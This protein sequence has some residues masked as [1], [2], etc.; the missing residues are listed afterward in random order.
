MTLKKALLIPLLGSVV[1]FALFSPQIAVSA[2]V[3]GH[4][5]SLTHGFALA[6]AV[7]IALQF[8]G[9]LVRS[10]KMQYVLKPIR[11][12]TTKFQFRALS[13]GYLFNTL[14]PLRLGELIRSYIMAAGEKMS[15]GLSL[16]LVLFERS[17]DAIILAIVIILLSVVGWIGGREAL[18]I[19]CLLMAFALLV[20]AMFWLSIKEN[21]LLIGAVNRISQLFNRRISREIRFKIWSVIYGLQKTLVAKRLLKYIAL[22]V[23]SWGLYILSMVVLVIQFTGVTSSYKN[24]VLASVG[25][26]IGVSIPAGPA[27]L[28]MYSSATNVI[29]KQ[30]VWTDEQRLVADLVSWAVLVLPICTVAVILLLIKTNEPL[31]RKLSAFSTKSSLMDK[32]ARHEDI[33]GDM[34]VFLDSYFAGNPLSKIVHNLE[35]EGSLH[36]LKYF[37]GGSDAITILVADDKQGVIVKK[38]ISI[39]YKDRL[40]AQYDWLRR[41]QGIGIVRALDETTAKDHYAIDLEYDEQNEMFFDFIHHSSMQENARVMKEVWQT[42]HDNLYKNTSTVTDYIALDAYIKKHI[43]GCLDMAAETHAGISRVIQCKNVQINGNKYDN[44]REIIKKIMANKQARKDLATFA[45]AAEV[46]GD[47]ALDNILVSRSTG[48]PLI[49]DPAP[50][51]NIINGPVFDFGK[52]MQSLYCGYE[53]LFRS[54]EKVVLENDNEI[55]FQDRR[56]GQY[57][58]LCE[59]VR[60]TLASEYLSEGEQKAMIFHAAALHIRRLKHQVKQNPDIALAMYAV[61]VRTLND[62]L[63]QYK[64]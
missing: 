56:S 17:M 30:L 38:I 4:V 59:Y 53:F 12:S 63:N 16:S 64:K 39:E 45:E 10:Y 33:S 37:K 15:W 21:R 32:L 19:I 61:G 27:G 43:W 2:S 36:L 9:H 8:A 51:G 5:I 47:I 25:P 52:N 40:K 57:I 54:E 23:V 41:H 60:N 14:F 48:K 34:E 7:S 1:L 24:V 62:F 6:I 46:D 28:G 55:N 22:S 18:L 11:H 42:L 49:I 35:K 13:I 44:I 58:E 31:R 50:D 29:N 26:Y 3:M 20:I